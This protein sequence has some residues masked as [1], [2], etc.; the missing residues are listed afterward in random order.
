MY[1]MLSQHQTSMLELMF[2]LHPHVVFIPFE[3][4]GCNTMYVDISKRFVCV[5]QN[6]EMLK[7]PNLTRLTAKRIL[8]EF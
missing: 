3:E 5:I 1:N 6:W 2:C 8:K 4:K 7:N